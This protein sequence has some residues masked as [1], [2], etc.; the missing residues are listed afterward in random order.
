[1]NCSVKHT[2]YQ[3]NDD[4][5]RCPKCGVG[6]Q[7]GEREETGFVID[8]G[9][10][11]SGECEKLHDEDDLLCYKCGYACSGKSFANYVVK[12]NSLVPC[13]CCKGTGY[14]SKESPN[15]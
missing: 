5:W 15:G 11:E 13:P 10:D 12:K 7:D 6:S 1:M 9:A 8:D 4:E 2:K 3:P 14:V